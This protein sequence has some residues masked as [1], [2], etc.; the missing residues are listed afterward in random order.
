M[1]EDD[2]KVNSKV[3]RILTEHNLDVSALTIS[4]VS[5]AVTIKGELR[6]LTAQEL[7]DHDIVRLLTVLETVI[8]RTKDV[9]RVTFSVRGW[10]KTKG[11]WG[12]EEK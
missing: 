3:R 10:K 7:N 12:K 11:R 2:L 4:S 5:G 8:L 6:K 1:S 9:K